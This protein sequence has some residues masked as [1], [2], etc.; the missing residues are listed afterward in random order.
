M[1]GLKVNVANAQKVKQYL[2]AHDLFDKRFAIKR[3]GESI[4]FPVVREF[5]PPF[6]FDVD[7]EEGEL[8]ERQ[9]TQSLREAVWPFLS[10]EEQKHVRT[11]YDIVGSI[12]IIDIPPELVQKEKL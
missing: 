7:F 8:D 3:E 10:E 4:S 11:A 12:A 2:I 1:L 9:L 5:S 6:D